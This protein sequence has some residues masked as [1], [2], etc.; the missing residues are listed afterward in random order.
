MPLGSVDLDCLCV[1]VFALGVRGS[2][3]VSI[4][5]LTAR[6]PASGNQSQ[7][8]CGGLSKTGASAAAHDCR[9]AAGERLR[10]TV[11]CGPLGDS[12]SLNS[13]SVG[14]QMD[15]PRCSHVAYG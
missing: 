3:C 14:D 4:C 11:K 15:R 1:C 13:L 10:P 12:I 7:C 6:Q 5:H 2:V 9:T 8:E